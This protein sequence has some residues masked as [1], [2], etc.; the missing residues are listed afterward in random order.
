MTFIDNSING[1]GNI[2]SWNWNF[3]DGNGT[4]T[5]QN[6][7]YTYDSCGIY[8]VQLIVTD[9]YSCSNTV[10]LPV[11]IYCEPTA[12]FNYVA[13]CVGENTI[14]TDNS[15][16]NNIIGWLWDMGG[17]G[18]YQSG[19]NN[20]S[21]NPEFLYDSCGT[22]TV[23]LV[24]IDAN[25]CTDLITLPVD[26]YCQPIANFSSNTVCQGDITI[27]SDLSNQGPNPSTPI[28]SYS[29]NMGTSGTYQNG[30]DN[31]SQN[32]QFIFDTCG[33]HNVELTV[34]DANGCTH[35]TTLPIEVY[36]NPTATF[37]ANSVCF[38]AQP[39]TFIDNSING[40]GNINSWNWNFGDGNGTSTD[41]NPQYT[42]DSCGIYDVQLIVTDNYSCSN[43][44]TLPVEIY[45][46]PNRE[47]ERL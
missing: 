28:V 41:Q 23:Q 21:Q 32:P 14:F 10:T 18:N 35:T 8:D 31:T 25:Q 20:L 9:N 43:T 29:W 30:T 34:T 26:V 1:T 36:C 24:I 37:S 38:D 45:C 2:N 13:E 46:E 40:T 27:F 44:V 16:P 17:N 47:R 22:Y 6:P 19:T 39:M 3:G 33:I 12:D 5:D 11:E 4:S 15:T 42:Y 7:Q